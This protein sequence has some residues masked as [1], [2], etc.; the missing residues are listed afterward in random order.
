MPVDLWTFAQIGWEA[1]CVMQVFEV[2]VIATN[3]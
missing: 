2:G 3:L 1:L